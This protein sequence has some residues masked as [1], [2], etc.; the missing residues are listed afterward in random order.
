MMLLSWRYYKLSNFSLPSRYTV[1]ETGLTLS[2]LLLH[3]QSGSTATL[4][5]LLEDVTVQPLYFGTVMISAVRISQLPLQRLSLWQLLW[6]S[7]LSLLWWQ[8][9]YMSLKGSAENDME[10]FP[11][12]SI[13]GNL[14]IGN[15]TITHVQLSI[16]YRTTEQYYQQNV[17][18][19]H[20]HS[21]N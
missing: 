2:C 19:M 13:Q 5:Q 8:Q 20:Q 15:V 16:S 1:L 17:Y 11:M 3:S 7:L 9:L 12:K 10:I 6:E 4:H 18:K 14:N 21:L